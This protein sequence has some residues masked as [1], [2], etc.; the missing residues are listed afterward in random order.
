MQVSLRYYGNHYCGGSIIDERH[1]IT[2]A[3]CC[4]YN[5]EYLISSATVTVVVGDLNILQTST[6]TVVKNLES[7]HVH[8]D[9]NSDLILNDIAIL[10]VSN[11]IK[12]VKYNGVKNSIFRYQILLETGQIL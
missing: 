3:H 4:Y 12:P 6:S 5:S 8:E 2:A 9:Y 11:R 10:K 1:V 7:V